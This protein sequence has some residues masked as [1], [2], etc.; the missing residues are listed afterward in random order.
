MRYHKTSDPWDVVWEINIEV[1]IVKYSVK[2][3]LN[4]FSIK[5]IKKTH[6]LLF[7]AFLHDSPFITQGSYTKTHKKTSESSSLIFWKKVEICLFHVCKPQNNLFLIVSQI[8]NGHLSCNTYSCHLYITLHS[9]L[10]NCVLG[11]PVGKHAFLP[12]AMAVPWL[13]KP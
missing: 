1:C 2:A 6:R 9:S 7:Y 3:N 10:I 13:R 4:Y 5:W 8:F 12:Q 11:L